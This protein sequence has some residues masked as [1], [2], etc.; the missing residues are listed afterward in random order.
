M[1]EV[2]LEVKN[3]SKSFKRHHNKKDSLKE[4][5]WSI[6]DKQD[7][8]DCFYA[9]TDIS[10]ELTQGEVLGI[11]GKNGAGKS[12]LL[13]ILSGVTWP[14]CGEVNFYGKTV[15]VLDVG[16]GFHPELTGRENVYLSGSLYGLSKLQ[17]AEKFEAIVDFSGVRS[18]IDEPLKTYS[19]GMYLRLAFSVVTSL[20]ADILMFDEVLYFGDDEFRFKS[21]RSIEELC[22]KGKTIILANH[23]YDFLMKVCDRIILLN[24]GKVANVF[25][26][27]TER[28]K[29]NEYLYE[30]LDVVQQSQTKRVPV[31][32]EANEAHQWENIKI[33]KITINAI[34]SEQVTVYSD[35]DTIIEVH[36]TLID[37]TCRYDF[38]LMFTDEK[39][40]VILSTSTI[41][42]KMIDLAQHAGSNVVRYVIEKNFFNSGTLILTLVVLKNMNEMLVRYKNIKKITINRLVQPANNMLGMHRKGLLNID[43]KWEHG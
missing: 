12:T 1:S 22:G 5:I 6:F 43:F 13:K 30:R 41:D 2:I 28:E 9:L 14:D 4:T 27:K 32:H 20:D 3:I 7:E 8:S 19:S 31:V 36:Y 16:A 33:E 24:D 18:F 35:Q 11:I 26:M 34:E 23:D 10:F 17:I 29:L 40:D 15:S 39:A 21:K 37:I 38:G 25:N 42:P